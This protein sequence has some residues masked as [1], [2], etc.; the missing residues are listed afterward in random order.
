MHF[1]RVRFRHIIEE[2]RKRRGHS[3]LSIPEALHKAGSQPIHALRRRMK[4]GAA[5]RHNDKEDKKQETPA[6]VTSDMLGRVEGGGIGILRPP[7]FTLSEKASEQDRL[8][9][10]VQPSSEG[11]TAVPSV[12]GQASSVASGSAEHLKLQ[13]KQASDAKEVKVPTSPGTGRPGSPRIVPDPSAPRSPAIAFFDA[14]DG[15]EHILHLGPHGQP[16]ISPRSPR[17]SSGLADVDMLS[18]ITSNDTNRNSRPFEL[19]PGSDQLQDPKTAGYGGFPTPLSI[20]SSLFQRVSPAAS[21]MLNEKIADT[22]TVPSTTVISGDLHKDEE[23][24]VPYIS[25]SAVVGR[26]SQFKDLTEEQLDELGGVEYRALKLLFWIV[27]SVRG[28]VQAD[29]STG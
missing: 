26:N 10:P 9:L 4:C 1:F 24:H 14:D 11:S 29:D 23:G 16:M 8:G 21:K 27:V 22:L 19:V 6:R 17:F 7:G 28:G 12:V 15:M 18:R 25:F 2:E 13:E 20:A 5:A 3:N